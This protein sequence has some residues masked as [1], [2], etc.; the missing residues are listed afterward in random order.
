[1]TSQTSEDATSDFS[2]TGGTDDVAGSDTSTKSAEMHSSQSSPGGQADR[3]GESSSTNSDDDDN[4]EVVVEGPPPPHGPGVTD[5]GSGGQPPPAT[6]PSVIKWWEYRTP[7]V[8]NAANNFANSIVTIDED[9]P[10]SVLIAEYQRAHD[11]VAKVYDYGKDHP[12]DLIPIGDLGRQV[13]FSQIIASFSNI[14]ITISGNLALQSGA[15]AAAYATGKVSININPT[16]SSVVTY[17]NI[18]NYHGTGRDYVIFHEIGHA[19]WFTNV[20]LHSAERD[21]D[22]TALNLSQAIGIPPL[23]T[24]P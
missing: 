19:L 3:S 11:N 6:G 13:T 24:N 1:M 4:P 14:A 15:E 7:S 17:N 20:D 12:N 5:S 16:V 18:N 23:N 22:I 2:S 10:S 8:S 9:R 21:A